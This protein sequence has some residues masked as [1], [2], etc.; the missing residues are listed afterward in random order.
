MTITA[1]ERAEI[2]RQNSRRSTGP[3]SPL[4]KSQS[5]MNAIKHGCRAKLPIIPGEDP[6]VYRDR[7]DSW[8]GKFDPRDP[9]EVYLVERAVNASW[10]L[11]RADRAEVAQLV[12]RP[13]AKP[14]GGSR[15]PP[16]W[17]PGSSDSPA[18]RRY[19][20][21]GGRSSTRG[22]APLLA[23]RPRPSGV[24]GPPGRRPGGHGGGLLLAAGEVGRT[25]TAPRAGSGL[26]ARRPAAGDPL[27]GQAAA[28]GDRR[29]GGPDDLPGVP[30]DGPGGPGCLRRA[31]ERPVP[32]RDGPAAA[33]VGGELR[34]GAGRAV[35]A[36]RGG[37]TVGAA[38]A[39]RGGDGAVSALREVREAA[40]A[41][42][43]SDIVARLPHSPR[44]RWIGCTSTR[45]IAPGPC[46][47]R[48]RSCGRSPGFHGR[49]VGG[50]RSWRADGLSPV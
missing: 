34:D 5:R 2:S 38:A 8:T 46:T 28:G 22:I 49:P 33:A 11:D 12:S 15:R 29:R 1:A 19:A 39:D 13:T 26:A 31:D 44:G 36:G 4:G 21:R 23:L 16:R 48:W 6:D 18:A 3:K 37:R 17:G 47:G 27:D 45:R 24:P 43:L 20:A 7:L 50:R 41:A 32:P 9:V 35:A 40:E 10:Q 14:P 25:G 42:D 30:G